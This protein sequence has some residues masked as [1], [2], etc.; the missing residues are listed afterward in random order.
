ML[1]FSFFLFFAVSV[2]LNLAK[3]R[4]QDVENITSKFPMSSNMRSYNILLNS[5]FNLRYPSGDC[6]NTR[7][8]LQGDHLGDLRLEVLYP[9]TFIVGAMSLPFAGK[10]LEYVSNGKPL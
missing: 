2:P 3:R 10:V 6:V 9:R 1:R 5:D 8:E 4:R 7:G